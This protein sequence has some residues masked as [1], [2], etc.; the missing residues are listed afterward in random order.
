LVVLSLNI[1][2]IIKLCIKNINLGNPKQFLIN[3]S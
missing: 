3:A 2:Y 1:H